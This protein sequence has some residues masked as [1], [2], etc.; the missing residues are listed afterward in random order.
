MDVKQLR[1][2][3]QLLRD[4]LAIFKR[5]YED[6]LYN[7]DD[8]NFSSR[9]IKEKGDM[10]TAI[11]QTAEE[12]SLQAESIDI[13]SKN[14]ASLEITSK[15]IESEVFQEN[16]DGTKTSRITQTANEITAIVQ[17]DYTDG[18]LNEY[19]VGINISPDSIKMINNQTYSE[20]IG[21]GLKFYDGEKQ[22]EG[23]AIEPNLNYGGTL[24]YYVNGGKCYSFGS[25][26]SG[27]GYNTTDMVIKALNGAR[28]RF[29]VDVS[30]SGYEEVKF[31]G[32]NLIS[33]EA[34]SPAIYANEKLLATQEW[35]LE[36]GSG[37]TA[38][39]A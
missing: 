5:K 3:V 32:L 25:E 9:F 33:G 37:G 4:E 24:N 29:V 15:D 39:F 6:L 27:N 18:I 1:N 11:E 16:D 2:E 8:D 22:T 30:G 36:N 20:Y 17:G 21:D 23:W 31:V 10:K 28:G 38:K 7:L 34:S 19:F 14:I 13:N 12:I 26:I 35:V